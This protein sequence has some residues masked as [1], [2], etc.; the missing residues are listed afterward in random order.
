MPGWGVNKNDEYVSLLDTAGDG[1]R[2]E[3]NAPPDGW[4][5]FIA[6][7]KRAAAENDV[8]EETLVAKVVGM[9]LQGGV[10]GAESAV[11]TALNTLN[12]EK[13]MK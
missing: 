11:Q 8:D 6:R 7:V 12:N 5:A 1:V 3:P 10:G 2:E 13:K 4:G 9:M